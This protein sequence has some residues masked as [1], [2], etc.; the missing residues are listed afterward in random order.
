MSI[1]VLSWLLSALAAL[2]LFGLGFGVHAVIFRRA[3]KDARNAI[4]GMMVQARRE[5]E[6]IVREGKLQAKDEILKARDRFE[7]DTRT[8][9]AEL[10]ETEER[11]ALRERNIDRKLDN[12]DKKDAA[13]ESRLQDL[14]RQRESLERKHREIEN[15][16][17]QT[18]SRLEAISGMT[19]DVAQQNLLKELNTELQ[20]ET[21]GL[22]RRAQ[23]EAHESAERDARKIITLAVERYAAEQIN[24][25]T[26]SAVPLPGDDMKGRI[27]G[28][29]GRNIRALEAATGVNILIDETP[30]VV[31]ISS[32]DP[33][34]RE[35]ARQSLE[36]LINDGRIHPA[37]IEEIVEKVR[38]E[39]SDI[40]QEAGEQAFY[41]LGLQA[42]DPAVVTMIGRLK[43]RHSYGQNVLKHSIEMGH[44]M[45]MMASEIGIDP[46]IARR[47]GLLH[48]IGKAMDH[49]LEG[50][51]A[52]L[53]AEFLK[54]HGETPLVIN[55]VGAHHN[56]VEAES[57][58]AI[59][60][61]AGDAM[62]AARPGAR[63]ENTEIYLK[64]LEKLEKIALAREG[65]EKCYAI[66][67]GREIRVI[68]EPTQIDDNQAMHLARDISRQI[69]RDMKYPGQVKVTVVRETRCVEY[70]R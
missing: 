68:V 36:R 27:I 24:E 45:G 51:H 38:Q 48:D 55:A 2:A 33:L 39:V 67:A 13:I 19:R 15:L 62:T 25:M 30:E 43:F 70:A 20:N 53:G 28:K 59:L 65:V 66:Q 49:E 35:I 23:Q 1:G 7:D 44:L 63:S 17:A 11:I 42:T 52:L 58:Y 5:S 69:E 10:R 12:L 56:E 14:D 21:A 8:R 64:R 16:R 60:A 41:E 34:R 37:R 57:L 4:E 50:S 6:S 32:F 61:R 26:T 18:T 9:R 46:S 3:R 54:K 22:V 47:V 29:E 31:V 40:I